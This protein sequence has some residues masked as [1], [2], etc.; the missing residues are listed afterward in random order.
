MGNT[1]FVKLWED[2]TY[3]EVWI[4]DQ[5]AWRIFEYLLVCAYRGKPQGTTVKTTQQITKACFPQDGK[6]NTTYKAIQR[7]VSH[8]MVTTESTNRMTVF[9]ITN[10]WKYQ[11]NGSLGK[12]QIKTKS[13]P[14]KTLYKNKDIRKEIYKEKTVARYKTPAELGLPELGVAT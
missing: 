6:N 4:Y 9:K 11:G 5:T 10:W 13:K 12:N 1:G 7:L 14:S 3:N 2:I 8:N